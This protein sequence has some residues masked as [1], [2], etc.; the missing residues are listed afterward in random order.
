MSIKLKVMS[1]VLYQQ[2]QHNGSAMEMWSILKQMAQQKQH[3][4]GLGDNK[5]SDITKYKQSWE[6]TNNNIQSITHLLR[7][8][9]LFIYC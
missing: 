7:V 8:F 5:L 6:K 4:K 3:I 1:K 9:Y 2:Q